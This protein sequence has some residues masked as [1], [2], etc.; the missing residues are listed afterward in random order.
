MAELLGTNT[1]SERVIR[2]LIA[3]MALCCDPLAVALTAG[4]SPR[5]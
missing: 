1:D 4:T 5:R 2:W 3:L